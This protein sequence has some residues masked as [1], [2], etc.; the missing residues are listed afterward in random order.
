MSFNT[1]TGRTL[2]VTARMVL[3]HLESTQDAILKSV[4][5]FTAKQDIERNPGRYAAALGL[6][7]PVVAAPVK[8]VK[9]LAELV[10]SRG[11][12][13]RYERAEKPIGFGGGSVAGLADDVVKPIGFGND[14]EK[15][16]TIALMV[17]APK[18]PSPPP[19]RPPAIELPDP[20]M[21]E[22]RQVE[23]DLDNVS[24]VEHF[25]DAVRDRDDDHD[26]ALYDPDTGEFFKRPPAAR[27]RRQAADGWVKSA[28]MTKTAGAAA[29]RP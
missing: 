5:W 22:E 16:E 6:V 9:T 2:T 21:E 25:L 14:L 24:E 10:V 3:A 17:S 13:P 18:P 19:A 11:R 28:L 15:I 27:R 1:G 26:P 4:M 12:S 7:L 29:A 8:K 23:H 20:Q